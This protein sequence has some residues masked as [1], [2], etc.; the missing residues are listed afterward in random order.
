MKRENLISE[1]ERKIMEQRRQSKEELRAIRSCLMGMRT[2][3]R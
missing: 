1:A 3:K 2:V